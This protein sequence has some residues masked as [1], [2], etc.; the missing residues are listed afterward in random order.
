MPTV[1]HTIMI[2]ITKIEEILSKKVAGLSTKI[3]KKRFVQK[4]K[5]NVKQSR[6]HN[7][8]NNYRSVIFIKYM[9]E[10]H[11]SKKLTY[12]EKVLPTILNAC[13]KTSKNN[14]IKQMQ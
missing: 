10:S 4:L 13:N 2:A 7:G 3:A 9:I 11:C 1:S 5:T 8:Y 6:N 14:I 12:D